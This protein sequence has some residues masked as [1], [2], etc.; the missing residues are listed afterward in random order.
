MEGFIVGCGGDF[1]IGALVGGVTV[2]DVG[3][4]GTLGE[5]LSKNVLKSGMFESSHRSVSVI[6][7]LGLT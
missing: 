6:P 7:I 4:V 1:P 5:G 2:D 3:L